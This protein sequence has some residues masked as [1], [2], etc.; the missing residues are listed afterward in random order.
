M[1]LIFIAFLCL[2]LTNCRGSN[3]YD[4]VQ[5][6][7]G[8]RGHSTVSQLVNI[9][10]NHLE[11]V[12]GGMR[13]DFYLDMDDNLLPNDGDLFEGS[14]VACNGNNGLDGQNGAPG[15]QGPPGQ[16]GP[17][18]L[19]GNPGHDGIPGVPGE[20]GPPGQGATI[21][22]HN[23]SSCSLLGSNFYLKTLPGASVGIYTNSS[24]TGS[25]DELNDAN[26]TFWLSESTLV[27]FVDGS[28]V[29]LITFN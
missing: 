22:N 6:P 17:P 18:G 28:T 26:S 20:Q 1:K 5:G 11:C 2:M 9:E 23:V 16:V 27:V 29:R 4:L 15:T 21:H 24:C 3:G 12:H 7:Q 8:P 19:N 10:D 14:L 25:H 13:V